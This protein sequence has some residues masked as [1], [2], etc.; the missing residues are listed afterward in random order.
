MSLS[1]VLVSVGKAL[2]DFALPSRCPACGIVV[3][4]DGNFCQPC[5]SMIKFLGE[6]CCVRCGTPMDAAPPEMINLG[7]EAAVHCAP[8]LAQP[9]LWDSARAALAY[10]DAA[11]IVAMRLKYG[12]RAA[13]AKVMAQYMIP[14]V[15]DAVREAGPDALILP[16]PLHRWRLW[17]RG[18]NQALAIA[19]PIGRRLSIPVEPFV[20]RRSRATRPLR[21]MNPRQ[22]KRAVQ[23]A[24]TVEAERRD[25]LRDKVILLVD[26]IHTSGATAAACTEVL[27]RHGAA[28]V[29]LLCWARVLDEGQARH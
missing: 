7:D 28:S 22:R 25:I 9:P 17:H 19:R 3:H 26:D 15:V 27:L 20:L 14:H 11:R 2:L 16:V 24:F 1:S 12:R 21:D 29:H 6:P 13:M 23:G 5:W 10:G 4:E 18:F 8:C